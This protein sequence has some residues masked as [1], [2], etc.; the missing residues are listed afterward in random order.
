MVISL[1]TI[2]LYFFRNR[3]DTGQNVLLL[4]LIYTQLSNFVINPTL[5][6]IT[7][8][9]ILGFRQFTI[10]EYTLLTIFLLKFITTRLF[11]KLIYVLSI[12]FYVICLYD[13]LKSKSSSFDSLPSGYAAILLII[14]SIFSLY[15]LIRTSDQSFLYDKSKFWFTTGYVMYFAGTFF[16][17]ISAQNNFQNP[18]YFSFFQ[19][20]N[21]FFSI[22]RNILFS[23][24][25]IIKPL[26]ENMKV[27]SK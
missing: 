10:L 8:N 22:V 12:T 2:G 17:F 23:V 20:L 16:I 4:Y 24:G 21:D 26:N 25:F 3:K 14:F 1:I 27:N 7:G 18:I 19:S 5:L 13:G 15:E 9:N 6:K 11:R